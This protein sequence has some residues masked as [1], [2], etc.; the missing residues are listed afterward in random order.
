MNLEL[1]DKELLVKFA[2][3]LRS[4]NLVVPAIFYL[5]MH[6]PFAFLISSFMHA[7]AP[8][9]CIFFSKEQYQRLSEIAEDRNTIEL[10][11]RYLEDDKLL[12]EADAS[13][14]REREECP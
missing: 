2:K 13:L 14:E 7:I 4:R 12:Q 3:A 10:L 6:K 1:E 8:I 5:E 9:V 11:V